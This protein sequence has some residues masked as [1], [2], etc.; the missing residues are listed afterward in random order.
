ML[1]WSPLLVEQILKQQ[2]TMTADS[3]ALGRPNLHNV[4]YAV[5]AMHHQPPSVQI[6]RQRLTSKTDRG[7]SCIVNNSPATK[8]VTYQMF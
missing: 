4:T 3:D 7:C 5:P 1:L 2:F 8:R 6:L